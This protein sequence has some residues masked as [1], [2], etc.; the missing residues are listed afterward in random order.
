MARDRRLAAGGAC[1]GGCSAMHGGYYLGIDVYAP[2][3]CALTCRGTG[4]ARAALVASDGTVAAQA[5]APLQTWR[6]ATDSRLYEQSSAQIWAAV[7]ACVRDV[8]RA[9][10][11]AREHVRG[12]GFDATCSLVVT[13]REGASVAVTP[14]SVRGADD[15]T[16]RN[17][18][19]WADHRAEEEAARINATKHMV[20]DYVGGTMSLEMEMPKVLWLQQRMDPHAF[21]RCEFF[22]LPDYLTFR[23]TDARARSHCSLVCK[24]AFVPPGVAGSTLGWQPDFLEQIGLG[25][26]AGADGRYAALGGIPGAGG[27]VLTGGMPVGAGLSETAA[28]ELGLLPHTPV[29]SALIDAYAGWIGTVAAQDDSHTSPH[30]ALA[31]SPARLVAIAGT[32]TC[33]C[34]Q[35][36]DGVHVPGVWGPYKNAV[37]PHMWMNEGGQS[38]TGQLLDF[39]L[40]T[41][42]AYADV[43]AEARTRHCSV[44]AVLEESLAAQM[45]AAQLPVDSPASYIW[46]VRHMHLYPDLYGNRSPLADPSLR[47]MLAG[48]SLD[49]SR[50]DLA[51]RYVLTLE[52][53][54]LQTRHILSEMNRS[55]HVIDAIYLS[56]G[57]QARN[58]VYAHLVADACGVRV[59]LPP[60]GSANVVTGSAVLGRLA[61]DVTSALA[62]TERASH[63]VVATQE[64]A[65][66]VAGEYADALWS[67]MEEMT[68]AGTS[69]YPAQNRARKALLDAKYKVR[70]KVFSQH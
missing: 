45:A 16:D 6:Y 59:Q 18:I 4:S 61:A 20:L 67:A 58:L 42:P 54:A 14:S 12:L 40:E 41:H 51:R 31:D 7:V 22:D 50:A 49:T 66:R 32:S 30:A 65:G 10:G 46:L 24:C 52:A 29:A 39:V 8:M 70:K 9:S 44:Y 27:L 69:I 2:A 37:F 11:V 17:V 62:G 33:Y 34:I 64:Q 47:G 19:L 28:R 3:A 57:G 43:A 1:K 68:P 26:L 63:A 38:S 23:A 21:A 15:A 48:I 5:A 36:E 35:S 25:A 60:E 55:G 53:I 56:G 13:D